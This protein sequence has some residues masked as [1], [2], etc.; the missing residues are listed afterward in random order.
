[1]VQEFAEKNIAPVAAELDQKEEYP[2]KILK[3]MAK[4]AK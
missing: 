3:E 2:T 1:M 4:L